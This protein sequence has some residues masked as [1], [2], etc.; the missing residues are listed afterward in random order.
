MNRYRFEDDDDGEDDGDDD[1]GHINTKADIFSNL[2][3][4]EDDD[5]SKLFGKKDKATKNAPNKPSYQRPP[6]D[7]NDTQN[8]HLFK[9]RL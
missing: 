3:S 7:P 1:E 4:R 8:R 6:A 5:V 9:E 2:E